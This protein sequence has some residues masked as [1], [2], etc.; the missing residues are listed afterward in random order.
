MEYNPDPNTRPG[1]SPVFSWGHPS[2]SPSSPLTPIPN[3]NSSK[4]VPKQKAIAIYTLCANRQNP[5]A[6]AAH[7]AVF[8]TARRCRGQFWFVV[9]PFVVAYWL[10]GWAEERY[11]LSEARTFGMLVNGKLGINLRT[12][13]R[14]GGWLRR[15]GC[16]LKMKRRR[17]KAAARNGF[18][19]RDS[20]WMM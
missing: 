16:N 2:T 13:R 19:I 10:M 4:E 11:G 15:G 20:R 6:G 12:R 7:N 9:P 3:T 8:N 1:Y 5:L 14:G 18:V 17:Q